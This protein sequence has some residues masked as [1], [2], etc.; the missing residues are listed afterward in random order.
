MLTREPVRPAITTLKL[1]E[2]RYGSVPR[3]YIR[4]TQDRAVSPYLQDLVIEKTGADRV[5]SL[6]ASHSAYFSKPVEL[7]DKILS[8]A[9]V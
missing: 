4:L 3:A 2:D 7:A 8:L 9:R 6:S 1:T 5:E